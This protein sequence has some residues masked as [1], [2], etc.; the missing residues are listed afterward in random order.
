MGDYTAPNPL[1]PRSLQSAF[2][3]LLCCGYF[4]ILIRGWMFLISFLQRKKHKIQRAG[5]D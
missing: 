1:L 3:I 5:K 2:N 4:Y